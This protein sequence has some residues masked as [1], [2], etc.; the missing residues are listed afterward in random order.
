M[1]VYKDTAKGTWTCKF[2]YTDWQGTRKQKKKEG[3]TTQ[4]EAKQFEADFMDKQSGAP[5]MTFGALCEHYMADCKARIKPTTYRTKSAIIDTK[6]RPFFESTP[7]NTITAATVRKWQTELISK[8]HAP[9]YLKVTNNQLSAVM[10]YA[11]KFY[12]LKENPCHKAGSMGKKRPEGLDF[13]T[14]D[15]FKR[16]S[17]TLEN[18][19]SSKTM[20]NLLFW[21][22]MRSGEALAL[23]GAD[24]DFVGNTVSISK[25]Y[26]RIKGKDFILPPKTPKS[27]RVITIPPFL[28]DMLQEYILHLHDYT[29]NERLFPYGKGWLVYR[30]NTG[31]KTSKVKKIRIH[32]LR[33]SHASLLIEMG[34]SP[35]LISE[36][37]GHEN[38][39]TTLQTYSHLYPNKQTE[40]A[41]QLQNLGGDKNDLN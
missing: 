39:E 4:R 2:R 1:S 13:W 7:I 32:D 18:D 11:V 5:D 40:L 37:L 20:F 25:N 14:L 27:K 23:T 22:G 41:S 28:A 8:G 31:C 35:L 9:T 3:F 38:I 26:A 6:V 36:R 24:F 29:P 12:G 16:F 30:M 10:N 33:H 19:I 34:F 21:T 17:K 15:E